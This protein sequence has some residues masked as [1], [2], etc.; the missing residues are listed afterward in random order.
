M[1]SSQI[2][3]AVVSFD[4]HNMVFVLRDGISLLRIARIHL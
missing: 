4:S 3:L 2:D 1:H